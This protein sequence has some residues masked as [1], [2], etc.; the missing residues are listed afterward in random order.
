MDNLAENKFHGASH[1]VFWAKQPATQKVQRPNLK[2]RKTLSVLV[3]KY[4]VSSPG[5][6]IEHCMV[7][8]DPKC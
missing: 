3:F 4:T 7:S 2:P 8:A 1:G 5:T 6:S